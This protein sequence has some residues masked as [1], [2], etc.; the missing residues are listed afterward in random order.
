[1]AKCQEQFGAH[2]KGRVGDVGQIKLTV[3]QE[4]NLTTGLI[5]LSLTL[6]SQVFF[7]KPKFKCRVPLIFAFRIRCLTEKKN[8]TASNIGHVS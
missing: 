6:F 8:C 3:E 2:G 1:M 7:V 4:L 5:I